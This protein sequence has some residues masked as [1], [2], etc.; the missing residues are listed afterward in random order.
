MPRERTRFFARGIF[1][2]FG[3]RRN[4]TAYDFGHGRSTIE[5]CRYLIARCGGLVTRDQ[6]AELLWPE[7]NPSHSAHRLHVA[8]SKLRLL[9]ADQAALVHSM[10]SITRSPQ[11]P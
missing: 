9:L 11:Q 1:G 3:L 4:G 7:A 8:I 10:A 5:L 2:A 6:L